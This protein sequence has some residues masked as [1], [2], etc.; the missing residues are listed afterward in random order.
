MKPNCN[1]TCEICECSLKMLINQV[2]AKSKKVHETEMSIKVTESS[3]YYEKFG[4]EAERRRDLK[5]QYEELKTNLTLEF[6][7]L[8]NLQRGIEN[9]KQ[10]ISKKQMTITINANKIIES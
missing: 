4:T 9:Q 2:K 7:A 10:I 5:M 8:E 3:N 1:G 6:T